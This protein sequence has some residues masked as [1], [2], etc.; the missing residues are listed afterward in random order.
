MRFATRVKPKTVIRCLILLCAIQGTL[1][2]LNQERT[3]VLSE[4]IGRYPLGEKGMVYVVLTDAGGAT[5]PYYYNYF[6]HRRI[7]DD[8]Q[9]LETLRQDGKAF[10]V[11][12]DWDAKI[13]VNGYQVKVSVRRQVNR[14]HTPADLTVDGEYTPVDIWLDAQVDY[15]KYR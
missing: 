6:V 15:S 9:A 11:T 1:L 2:F 12:R 3:P 7:D 13:A 8:E 10:L 4:I 14:F 5:V